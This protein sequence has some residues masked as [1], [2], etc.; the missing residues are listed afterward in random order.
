MEPLTS[1]DRKWLMGLASGAVLIAG[2]FGLCMIRITGGHLMAPLDDTFIY[3][4]YA[5]ELAH[6]RWFAYGPDAAYS[7]GASSFLYPFFLVPGFW[8]GLDGARALL[9]VDALGV[10]LYA[11]SAM[12]VFLAARRLGGSVAGAIA[13]LLYLATG[14][15]GWGYLSG[16]ETGFYA[17]VLLATFLAWS[18]WLQRGERN[19]LAL[20]VVLSWALSLS[21][22]EGLLLVAG[23]GGFV[24]L[25][26]LYGRLQTRNLLLVPVLAIAGVI[27]LEMNFYL[28]GQ[29]STNGWDSKSLFRNPYYTAS[30]IWGM[31]ARS[32]NYIWTVY[33]MNFSALPGFKVN[34]P[35]PYVPMLSGILFL[36]GVAPGAYA[37]LRERRPGPFVLLALL[38]FLGLGATT[39]S[40]APFGHNH[41]YQLAYTPLLIVGAT[42]GLKFLGQIA[43]EKSEW[44]FVGLSAA[45]MLVGLPSVLYWGVEFGENA[46]NLFHQHRRMS[47]IVEA[48]TGKDDVVGA[49]DVGIMGYYTGRRIFDF[50]G[51][52]TNG[53]SRYWRAGMG[54]A[55]ERLER[56]DPT[57]RP[58]WIVTHEYLFGEPNFLG[59][60]VEDVFIQ[61][62]TITSGDRFSLFRPNWDYVNSADRTDLLQTDDAAATPSLR[63]TLVDR[64]D[65]ADLDDEAAH[66]YQFWDGINRRPYLPWPY[67]GNVF[68][69]LQTVARVPDAGG[70]V[71]R[72]EIWD[73]GRCL[74]GGERFV[75]AT[76]RGEPLRIIM[77]TDAGPD[78]EFARPT[79]LEV[80]IGSEMIG[81]WKIP[82]RQ[83]EPHWQHETFLVPANKIGDARTRMEIVYDYDHVGEPNHRPFHYFFFQ[84]T[85]DAK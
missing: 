44:V 41:R 73:G 4:T 48:Q 74:S 67:R 83:G 85:A 82:A 23:I 12:L 17:A 14:H 65:V 46:N 54:S 52:V 26:W 84:P 28:S 64:L 19:D 68:R 33:F 70:E 43:R 2:F 78:A 58:N 51:L 11:A 56:M 30:D 38:L 31:A 18:R 53:Q 49:T 37:E 21:R 3:L 76:K 47:W 62:N 10:I 80:R 42:M 69:K 25:Y 36:L 55:W 79:Q 40:E 39:L 35:V 9:W 63:W 6:G 15:L 61:H 71:L 8:L 34:Q 57:D 75:V 50:V 66:K 77:R 1:S 29:I 20:A 45:I 24:I 72:T 27:Y 13:G 5:R 60:K 59:Q 81:I 16:M 22:P 7:T 32:W